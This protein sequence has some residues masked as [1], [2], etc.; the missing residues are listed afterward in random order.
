M[1]KR[2]NI[3]AVL[4]SSSS[5]A[6]EWEAAHVVGRMAANAGW[7]VLTGGGPG[8]M[9]AASRGAAE[10]G[11]LTI[12]VL[13]GSTADD[14]YPNPWVR[15]PIYTG[16]GPA[17]NV[18]NVLSGDLCLAIGGRAG[19]L[20][21][22]AHAAKEGREL[23]WLWPWRLEASNGHPRLDIRPFDSLDGVLEALQE[24]FGSEDA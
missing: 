15:V 12:G 2:I 19:T 21:E 6:E 13:M 22:V 3:L 10:A 16:L 24:R 14:E 20:S 18:V 5:T 8:V 11:G 1:N 23:W 7:A 9:E 17:R 4:G